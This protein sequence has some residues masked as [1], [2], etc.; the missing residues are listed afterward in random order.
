MVVNS[1]FCG[2]TGLQQLV[3]D[4]PARK[5]ISAKG[6]WWQLEGWSII[7]V[8]FIIVQVLEDEAREQGRGIHVIVLN[9]ATVS[10]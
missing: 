7:I 10:D 5:L 8:S 6:V 1:Q 2:A 9:Q 3:G 4:I